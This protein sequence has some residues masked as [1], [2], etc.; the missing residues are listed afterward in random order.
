M[1]CLHWFIQDVLGVVFINYLIAS[2]VAVFLIAAELFYLKKQRLLCFKS[3][4]S[5][6]GDDTYT[7]KSSWLVVVCIVILFFSTSFFL[8][9]NCSNWLN[10]S[11]LIILSFVV[12][13]SAFVD[14]RKKIIPN[15]LVLFGLVARIVVYIIEFIYSEAFK[16]ILINDLI[17]FAIGF[18]ILFLS[19]VL[20]KQ[21]VGFGD[22]KLFGVIGLM[23]GAICTFSTLILSLLT[24]SVVSIIMIVLKKR[25]KK[26]S[27]PFGP[28]I[29]VGYFFTL[30]FANY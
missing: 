12:S 23:S 3:D 9:F 26:D 29:L 24:S 17:G 25:S 8:T 19:A 18:G 11:K 6:T 13:S 7:P 30:I 4:E 10:F 15:H 14:L 27:L 21:A 22:V 28:F 2:L 16:Q 1:W 5:F 20:S